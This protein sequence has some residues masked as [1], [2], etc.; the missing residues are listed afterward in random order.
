MQ[1]KS[2]EEVKAEI[3]AE[4][5]QGA[6]YSTGVMDWAVRERMRT[7]RYEDVDPD[8][9][10]EAQK[11]ISMEATCIEWGATAEQSV[12]LCAERLQAIREAALSLRES[13]NAS[14]APQEERK[15]RE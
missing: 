2:K 7:Y 3:L 13:P 5:P 12:E 10:I 8:L 9:R 4:W 15:E 14:P 11:I 6:L 1:L